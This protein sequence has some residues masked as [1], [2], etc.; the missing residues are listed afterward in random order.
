MATKNAKGTKAPKNTTTALVKWEEEMAQA[1]ERGAAQEKPAGEFKAIKIQ[2]GVLMVDDTPIPGNTL[3]GVVLTALPEN[4]YFASNYVAGES[5]VPDCYAFGDLDSDD[6]EETMAPHAEA[7]NP[8]H[9]GDCASCP[10]NQWGS[11]DVG[12]GKACK[13]TRRLAI[14][15]EDALEDAESIEQ[16]EVRTLSVPVTS[17]KHWKGYVRNKLPEIKR[18]SYG[19]VT[20]IT[21]TPDPK[22]QFKVTFTLGGLIDF[23][24]DTYAAMKAKVAAARK[25]IV[26]PYPQKTEEEPQP[27]GR[28]NGRVRLPQAGKGKTKPAAKAAPKKQRGKF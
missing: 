20:V 3:R 16:A 23:N 22:T 7:T 14:I 15:T 17:V 2:G 24:G 21:V 19:V 4:K 1:A 28:G 9:E 18:P 25:D 8:Q 12:K 10:L 5:S 13:N 6:P 26:A 11:A 27:K